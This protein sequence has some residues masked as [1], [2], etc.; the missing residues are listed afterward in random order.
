MAQRQAFTCD[1]GCGEEVGVRSN[2]VIYLVVGTTDNGQ[3]DE[4][5]QLPPQV[6]A[7]LKSAVPRKDYCAACFAEAFGTPLVTLEAYEASVS[8]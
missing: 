8:A 4:K 5:V 1:G 6:W 2:P 7:I 3:M